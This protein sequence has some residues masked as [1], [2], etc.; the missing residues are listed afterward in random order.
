MA[1]ATAPPAPPRSDQ[2]QNGDADPLQHLPAPAHD[3]AAIVRAARA[4]M[5]RTTSGWIRRTSAK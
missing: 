5:R 4:S 3:E 1:A 2:R